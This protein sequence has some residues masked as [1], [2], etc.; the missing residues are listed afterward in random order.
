VAAI[1]TYF[2]LHTVAPVEY[3]AFDDPNLD[4]DNI[5]AFEDDSPYPEV[6]SAVANT[7]DPEMPVSTFRA[8]LFGLIWAIII[9][10]LNQF[11]YF[12]YPSVT[13]SSIVA[14]LISFPMLR[15]YARIVPQVKIF[16]ISINPGP[17]TVKE[18]VLIT[19]MAGVGAGSAYAVSFNQNHR[20][21][22]LADLQSADR[23]YCRPAHFL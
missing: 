9:P 18:H 5:A 14:Q 22:S 7:D 4:V 11:F 10:G 3:G 17:F 12:R 23:H 2:A 13:I 8:W 1:S 20:I 19:I 6:R 16:G 21:R 15:L